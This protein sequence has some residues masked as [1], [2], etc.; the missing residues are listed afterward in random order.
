MIYNFPVI[1]L[2]TGIGGHV[3]VKLVYKKTLSFWSRIMAV[4]VS[5][6]PFSSAKSATFKVATDA[7]L[8]EL[9]NS[10]D[11]IMKKVK[12]LENKL[13]VMKDSGNLPQLNILQDEIDNLKTQ[14]GVLS[15]NVSSLRSKIDQATQ[16]V[17]DLR[18]SSYN[19]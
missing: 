13:Q 15:S 19:F 11:A 7:N 12:S 16:R 9:T 6:F 8:T 17:A 14:A 10:Y 2:I 3:M 1:N 4:F 18:S 5:L